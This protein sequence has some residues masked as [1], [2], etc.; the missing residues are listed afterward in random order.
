[1]TLKLTNYCLILV[2]CSTMFGQS[3]DNNIL[4]TSTWTVGSG[5]VS[6]FSQNGTNAE[7][8]REY[9]LNH[10]GDQ[11]VLWKAVPDSNSNSDGGWN[12]SYY[13]ISNSK[14]YRFSVW[15]KKTNSIVGSTYFGCQQWTSSPVDSKK[16]L[17]LN[18]NY[19]NNPYFF[20]G[21]LPELDKWYLLVGYI[22]HKNYTQTNNI[23]AIYD[24]KTG[25]FVQNLTDFKFASTTTQIRHRAYLYYDTN[26]NDR[27]YFY[28]PRI[29]EVNGQEWTLNQLLRINPNSKLLFAYDN[30]G[31]QK[32]R[33]YCPMPGCSVPNPPSGR[34]ST[35][36]IVAS[37]DDIL[38]EDETI[39]EDDAG[40]LEK[41]LVV[42]PNP[43][44]GQLLLRLNSRSNISLANNIMIYN[45]SGALMRSIP[46]TN[47]NELRLDLTDLSEGMYLI[48][49][50]LSD[51][52]SITKQ[53]IK[54]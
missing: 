39:E 51:G 13:S 42:Y 34:T 11:V 18:G 54:N 44:K 15:I 33:F 12:S 53:I 35:E 48:H 20:N 30:A 27:Q 24:G 50:H 7:N 19:Q 38:I 41:E 47:N 17:R 1:M 28:A 43:T 32:Q 29:E 36:D 40:S 45:S 16:V 46:S 52:Q 3:S 4:D 2:F 8:I 22:H 25:E 21:D 49:I 37:K 10:V 9:G 26:T 6:G 14:T 5:S 23:G 31:S